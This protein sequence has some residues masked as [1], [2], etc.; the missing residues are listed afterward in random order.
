MAI[1]VSLG[2]A[3]LTDA[4]LN[5][6]AVGVENGLTANAAVFTTP[7][8]SVASLTAGQKAFESALAA[9]NGGGLQQTAIKDASH[10]ALIGLLRQEALYV[11]Q[12]ANGDQAK[13]LSAGFQIAATGHNPQAPMPK[14]VIAQILNAGSGQLL[15]RLQPIPN[16]HAYEGQFSTTANN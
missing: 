1:H 11:Q 13:I 10:D 9:A 2:F 3:Q 12:T 4:D 15:V 8:V 16:A 7:P 6:F 5:N 14:T